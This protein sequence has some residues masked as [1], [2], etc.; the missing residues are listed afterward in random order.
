MN[1]QE[2][3]E[4]ISDNGLKVEQLVKTEVEDDPEVKTESEGKNEGNAE[5]VAEEEDI[6]E[7]GTT[8]EEGIQDQAVVEDGDAVFMGK[9][10]VA[11]AVTGLP[12]PTEEDI[13]KAEEENKKDIK[14]RA[15]DKLKKEIEENKDGFCK[16]VISHLLE[17]V[18][19]DAGLADDI[20]Q[21]H[22][23]WKKCHDYIYANA[24]KQASGNCAAV[25]D[26]MVYEWAEDYYHK[27]DKELEEKK[28]A[29]AKKAEHGKKKV[30]QRNAVSNVSAVKAP[31]VEKPKTEVKKES[32]S[33]QKSEPKKEAHKSS[34]GE[35]E[36]QMD[37]FSFM[38]M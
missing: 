1:V 25:Q 34:K 16:V 36:G 33:V 32:E 7:A 15:E 10:S 24:R 5:C 11:E 12:A 3:N 14:Q 18:K 28:A 26:D 30:I 35:M 9:C 19:D 20:L 23:T 13:R 17:R 2:W 4:E 27:D 8:A 38:N 31:T 37:L 6:P 21:P 29:D 22:K